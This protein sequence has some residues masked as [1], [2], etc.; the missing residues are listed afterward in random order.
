[1]AEDLW[2]I[3]RERLDRYQASPAVRAI[4]EQAMWEA[5]SRVDIHSVRWSEARANVNRFVDAMAEIA[6]ERQ[7]IELQEEV[8]FA[9]RSRL[10]PLFPI[11]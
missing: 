9:A 5:Q 3:A 10:C 2:T 11:C 8:Y 6:A 4:P 7:Q 1:M